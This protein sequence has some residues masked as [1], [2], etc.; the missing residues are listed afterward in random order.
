MLVE[1]ANWPSTAAPMPP[2]PKASPKNKPEI[3]PDAAGHQLLRVDQMAGER[4][5]QHQADD[6]GERSGPEQVGVRQQQRERQDAE[7]GAPDHVFAAD[8]IADGTADDGARGDRA[9]KHEQ[10]HLRGLHRDVEPG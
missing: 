9:E 10:V 4:R 7:D 3:G 2:M 8:A 6:H 1:S 5:R